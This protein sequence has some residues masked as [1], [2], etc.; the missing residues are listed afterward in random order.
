M[1]AYGGYDQGVRGVR[2]HAASRRSRTVDRRRSRLPEGLTARGH[3]RR[4]SCRL[5]P[6]AIAGST[7]LMLIVNLYAAARSAQ[8]SQ[9]LAPAVARRADARCALP[10]PLAVVALAALAPGLRLPAPASQFAWSSLG[11]PRRRLRPAGA[12]GAAC[13]VAP[14]AGAPGA[15]RGALSSLPRRARIGS[16]RRSRII[17]LI[18]SFAA[19]RARAAAR[20]SAKT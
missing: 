12:G 13:A 1:I 9:R 17:G 10:A 20:Q 5:S 4:A 18:E 15:D 2:R 7:L 11:A 8:L 6:A 14:R 3:S 16:A 19:L